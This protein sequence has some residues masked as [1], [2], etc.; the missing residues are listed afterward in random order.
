MFD[1]GLLETLVK[2]ASLGTSG[3]CIFAIFWIGWLISRPVTSLD[4][5][6]QR[7][8]RFF[9]VVCVVISLVSAGTGLWSGRI[10]AQEIASLQERIRECETR[11]K[12]YRVR[13]TVEKDDNSGLGDVL[14]TPHHPPKTTDGSGRIIDLFV[15][16][17]HKGNLPSLSFFC[18]GYYL[19]GLYLDDQDLTNDVIEI[20]TV[21]LRKIPDE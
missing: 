1:N 2:L 18:P 9:M 21:T 5:E 11:N 8:L 16:K 6:R 13:G 4:K 3:I 14:I 12:Q 10:D 20:S 15:R 19:E 17:D 7:T